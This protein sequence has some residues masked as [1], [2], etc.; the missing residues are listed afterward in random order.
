MKLTHD[1]KLTLYDLNIRPDKKHFIVEDSASGDFY[2]MPKICID[3]IEFMKNGENLGEIENQLKVDYPE[4]EVDIYSFTEQLVEF[5]LVKEINGEA[6][7]V[8][9]NTHSS[10]GFEWIPSKIAKVFF[11][12]ITNKLYMLLLVINISLVVFNPELMPHYSDIFLFESMTLNMLTYMALSLVLIIIHEYGHILAI[13][14]H[15]L[16]AKLDIGNRLFLVV[17]ETDLSPAWKLTPRERNPLYFAGMSFEQVVIFISFLTMLFFTESN[18]IIAGLLSMVVLDIFIKSIYQL[19]FFMKTDMYYIVE[20]WTG[21]YNLMENGKQYLSKWIPFIKTD[22]T[23]EAFDDELP[24]I[25]LY[26]W[27]YLLGILLMFLLLG[28]Y[29]IPQTIHALYH[30]IENLWLPN[31]PYFWDSVIFL[32]QAILMIGLLLYAKLKK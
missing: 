5:G 3:A 14:S 16:P 15:N 29:I 6:V 28:F 23:T 21:S 4:D 9:K 32:G 13:R 8:S 19:S 31:G 20:N 25:R 7:T 10:K 26:S 30:V 2:E 27:F 12:K 1:T 11:N 18:S 22:D 24:A 17:F